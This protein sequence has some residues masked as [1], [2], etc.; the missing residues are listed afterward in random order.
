MIKKILIDKVGSSDWT[1][2]KLLTFVLLI[3]FLVLVILGVT[4]NGLRPLIERIE[5]KFNEV[6]ILFHVKDGGGGDGC[7]YDV[8]NLGEIGDGKL[9]LCKKNCS[10]EI[11]NDIFLGGGSSNFFR[12]NSDGFSR[13]LENLDFWERTYTVDDIKKAETEREAYYSLLKIFNWVFGVEGYDEEKFK[14]VLGTI[15]TNTFEFK[16]YGNNAIYRWNGENWKVA[17]RHSRTID[18][19]TGI[20]ELW[21]EY[22]GGRRVSWRYRIEDERWKIPMTENLG[23]SGTVKIAGWFYG[24]KSAS[25][26]D[27]KNWINKKIDDWNS[28]MGLHNSE[29]EKLKEKSSEALIYFE[30]G[31]YAYD[32]GESIVGGPSIHKYPIMYFKVNEDKA[33]GLYF[34][35]DILQLVYY[36]SS[37]SQ[38][39][40]YD[41][42]LR[43]SE[44]DWEGAKK[45]KIISDVLHKYC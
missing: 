12:V 19:E 42:F 41:S 39:S 28:D 22:S 27:F 26:V 11:D 21:K 16:V 23:K 36:N 14:I 7:V 17:D 31:N 29:I 33:Y 35:D 20:K 1:I 4:T 32:I 34:D 24:D 25:D 10:M 44:E 38:V 43:L 2:G 8:V 40:N 13:Y 15:P 3:I 18:R 9:V 45:I 30:K 6:L 5:G 37:K